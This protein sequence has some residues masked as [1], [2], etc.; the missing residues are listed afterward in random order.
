MK[1][2]FRVAT[3]DI[4]TTA[5][6][7]VGAGVILCAVIKPLGGKEKVLRYD[8]MHLSA[9]NDKKLVRAIVNELCKYD[10]LVGHNI[11]KFDWNFIKTRALIHNI[12]IPQRPYFYDTMQAFKR[13][14]Y[15][16][17]QNHFGK[18]TARLDMVVDM[19]GIKQRKTALYPRHH[20]QTVWGQKKT[21]KEAMNALVEHCVLDVEMNQ[22]IYTR[23]FPLDTNCAL[24]RFK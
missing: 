5:L 16:T 15:L 23:L 10:L 20:W 12:P 13:C 19:F 9:G 21:R 14:G 24:K 8:A 2:T 18:P 11:F 22:D 4:E 3:F 17:V 6:D 1:P 7:A